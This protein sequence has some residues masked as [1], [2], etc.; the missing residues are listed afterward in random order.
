MH[1]I[2]RSDRFRWFKGTIVRD[3]L[4]LFF[5]SWSTPCRLMSHTLNY[6]WIRFQFR[7]DIRIRKLFSRVWYPAEIYLEGYQILRKFIQRGLIPP[8]W[9]SFRSVSDPAKWNAIIFGEIW[10]GIRPHR[11]LSRGVSDPAE[12][13]L[14]AEQELH[15][16]VHAAGPDETT[17]K[18]V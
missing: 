13:C 14:E 5:C 17:Q 9:N 8:C 4:T 3:F 11:N 6:F 1:K 16:H 2:A 15:Y 12:I 18:F 7:G 10:R